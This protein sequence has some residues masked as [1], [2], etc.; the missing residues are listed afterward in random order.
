MSDADSLKLDT[1]SLYEFNGRPVAIRPINGMGK[2]NLCNNIAKWT[3]FELWGG[4]RFD[5]DA[6]EVLVVWHWCG[7]C[8]EPFPPINSVR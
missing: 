3:I 6:K 5:D 4:R 7:Q 1:L 2:C 8:D